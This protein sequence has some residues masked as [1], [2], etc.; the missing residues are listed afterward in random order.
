VLAEQ[1]KDLGES[2]GRMATDPLKS[3]F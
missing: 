3:K 1:A 2:T